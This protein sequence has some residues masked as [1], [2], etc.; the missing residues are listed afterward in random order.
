MEAQRGHGVH[1]ANFELSSHSNPGLR[2]APLRL[3]LFVTAPLLPLGRSERKD[4]S[5]PKTQ[6]ESGLCPDSHSAPNKRVSLNPLPSTRFYH[7]L[8]LMTS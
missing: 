6:G 7:I 1:T 5:V 4:G 8:T 3:S 2:G